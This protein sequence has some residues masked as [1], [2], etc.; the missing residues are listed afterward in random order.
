MLLYATMLLCY[1]RQG[2]RPIFGC[3]RGQNEDVQELKEWKEQK[4]TEKDPSHDKFMG[5]TI[6]STTQQ[7]YSEVCAPPGSDG[8]SCQ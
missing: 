5:Q 7:N 2:W 3:T 6:E 4:Q 1:S 8:L